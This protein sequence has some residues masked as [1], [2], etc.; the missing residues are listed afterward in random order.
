M[1]ILASASPRRRELLLQAGFTFIVEAADLDETPL[2]N[3]AAAEYVE[4]LA[5]EKAQAV[6][7]LRIVI[8]RSR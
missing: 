5:R 7:A 8:N 2:P 4:R 3:E 6:F 1:L